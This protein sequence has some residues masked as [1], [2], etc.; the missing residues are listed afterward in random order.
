MHF[1]AMIVLAANLVTPLIPQFT[2][3]IYGQ[4]MFNLGIF[5]TLTSF[6]W[7][8]FSFTLGKIG[9]KQ[10]KIDAI[11]MA[12][13]ICSLAFLIIALIN[14]FPLLCFASFLSGAARITIGFAPGIVGSDAPKRSVGRWISIVQTSMYIAQF[15]APVIGGILYEVTPHLAFFTSIVLLLFLIVV[16]MFKKIMRRIGFSGHVRSLRHFFSL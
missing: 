14:N 12:S 5:G 13:I 11:L 8:F 16:A 7:I 6:G 4:S 1:F 3:N 10:S 9:D 15:L 2:H